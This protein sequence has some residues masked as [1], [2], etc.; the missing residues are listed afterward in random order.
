VED[1]RA[2]ST[3]ERLRYRASRHPATILSAYVTIFLVNVC[4]L[5]LVRRPGTHWDSAVSLAA[6]AGLIVGLWLLGGF[7]A[8]FF[9]VLLPMAIATALGGYLFYAQHNFAEVRIA[10]E[11]EWTRDRASLESASFMRLPFVLRW[12]AGNIGYHHV[13]HVNQLIP[14]YRLPVAMAGIPEFQAPLV[15]TLHP[16]EV[17]SC[18]QA[19]LWDETRGRMVRYRDAAPRG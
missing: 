8:A 11:S 6:H 15:T 1:W 14:F 17:V 4:I 9:A 18:F 2:S 13:H 16:R 7:A 19:N 10:P 12:F 5:P 3:L